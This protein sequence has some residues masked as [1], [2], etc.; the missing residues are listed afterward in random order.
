MVLLD[1][2]DKSLISR[3]DHWDRAARMGESRVMEV[4]RCWPRQAERVLR[5]RLRKSI[6]LM[7]G[8]Y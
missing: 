1:D 4:G 6:A 5:R 2:G 3:F 7:K 8:L